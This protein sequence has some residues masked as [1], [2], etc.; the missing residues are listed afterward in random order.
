MVPKG[1]NAKLTCYWSGPWII[2]TGPTSSESLL[3][4][5]P[6]HTWAK[7]L[8]SSGTWVVSIDSLRFYNNAKAVQVPENEDDIEG[9]NNEFAENISLS[10]TPNPVAPPGTAAAPS[11]NNDARKAPFK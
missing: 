8:K 4:I 3:R 2:C 9:D 11:T 5:A 10:A 6:D 7:Q 1:T